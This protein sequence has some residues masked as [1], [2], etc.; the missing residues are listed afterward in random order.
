MDD[1]EF[2]AILQASNHGDKPGDLYLLPDFDHFDDVGPTVADAFQLHNIFQ[3]GSEPP[4][5]RAPVTETPVTDTL[6]R[7]AIALAQAQRGD[8]SWERE[9]LAQ[10]QSQAYSKARTQAPTI[11]DQLKGAVNALGATQQPSVIIPQLQIE[12]QAQ[13]QS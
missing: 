6:A 2:A 8:I 13:V 10:E 12:A 9:A 7:Q 4:V 3:A 5:S 11:V 1:H